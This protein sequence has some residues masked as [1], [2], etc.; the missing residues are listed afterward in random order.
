MRRPRRRRP[1]RAH[2]EYAPHRVRRPPLGAPIARCRT[3]CRTSS[4]GVL[5]ERL[6]RFGA[7]VTFV[8]RQILMEWAK[9]WKLVY[10]CGMTPQKL[11]DLIDHN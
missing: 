9:D 8:L 7:A 4:P 11:P 6:L 2:G 10:H 3:S 5:P 1:S